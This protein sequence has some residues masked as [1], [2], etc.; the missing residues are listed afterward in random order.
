[1]ILTLLIGLALIGSS[2]ALIARALSLTA[3]S[4]SNRVRQIREYS[5]AMATTAPAAASAGSGG[6]GSAIDETASRLGRWTARH[7]GGFRE[8]E[9]RAQLT[10]AGLYTVSPL[11]FLGYRVLSTILVPAVL[12]WMFSLR[13]GPVV[14]VL[15]A[16]AFGLL[17]G[18]VLPMT[19]L[20]RKADQ[21]FDHVERDLPELVDVLVLTVEAG[22]G[23]TGA[24]QLAAARLVGPLGDELRL[25]LQEQSMGLSINAALSNLLERCET[26]SMRSFV[27][28]VLQGETLGVS[29]GT[30]LRNLAIEMRKRRRARAEER[31]QKAPIKILFPLI[32][33][34][35]PSLFAVLLY[36]AIVEFVQAI[37]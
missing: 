9:L 26:P 5:S 34:I 18:W 35:F 2:V 4:S 13:G 29:M 24:M 28:S 19:Y 20:R 33:L 25:T 10:A 16:G 7:L 21:R 17:A 37:G 22:L 1:M 36:P 3:V 6:I 30:I 23:F 14:F 31:A 8:D 12:V 27:R 11:T 15:F 32:F